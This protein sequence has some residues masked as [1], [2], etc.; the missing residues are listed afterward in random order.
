MEPKIESE[1]AHSVTAKQYVVT[2]AAERCIITQSARKSV[3]AT[4]AKEIIVSKP[5]GQT[6]GLVC[7][8]QGFIAKS[9]KKS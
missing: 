2:I 5:T 8:R 1:A 7:T 6:I 9:P 4:Q 3:I